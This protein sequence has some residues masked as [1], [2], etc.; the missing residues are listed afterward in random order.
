MTI[1][2]KDKL[3]ALLGKIRDCKDCRPKPEYTPVVYSAEDPDILIVSEG[4]PETAWK[5][6]LGKKWRT[7]T[8]WKKNVASTTK[9]L[10]SWLELTADE[11]AKRLFWIQRANCFYPQGKERNQAFEYCSKKYIPRAISAVEP[12][13]IIALGQ[14]AAKWF[15]QFHHLYEIVGNKERTTYSVDGK[16]YPCFA[17]LHPSPLN[18]KHL[19]E[20]K[21]EQER[22][23][24]LIKAIIH[25]P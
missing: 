2:K 21:D 3:N 4:P 1:S 17:L 11:A 7:S 14:S 23:L 24:E 19:K 12:D 6:D 15:F 16:K 25:G 20:Y 8:G 22:A 13:L 9:D 5:G 18:R 10:I